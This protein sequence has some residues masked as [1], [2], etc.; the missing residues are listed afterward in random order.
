[1][2]I[3]LPRRALFV[4]ACFIGALLLAPSAYADGVPL[5]R[6]DVL[7]GVGSGVVKHFD[8]NGNL[9]DTLDTTTGST[10]TTGMCFA[11]GGN[12]YV[13]TFNQNTTSVF[14][15]NGNL[16]Q[17]NFGSGYGSDPE[18]CTTNQAGDVFAGQADGSTNILEFDPNGN[19]INTFAPT[20]SPRGTDWIDL[21]SDQCTMQYTSEGSAIHQFNVCTNTQL[22]DFATGLPGGACFAHRILPDGSVLVACSSEVVH[23][24]SSGNI[25]T[26]YPEP[27]D[28]S[29][30]LFALNIDPDGTSFW[31]GGL[32]T[33]D[34]WKI[35]IASGNELEHFNAGINTALGGLA[36][37]GEFTAGSDPTITASGTAVSAIEGRPFSGHVATFTDPDTTA[38]PSDY[39]ATINWGDG[40]TSTGT[41]SGSGGN[42]TVTGTH[43]YA[44]EGSFTVHVTITDTDNSENTA[45][46]T[47]K[48]T[49]ADAALTATGVVPSRS[50][51]SASGTVATFTDADP[52]GTVSDYTASINW[53]DGATSTG[54][55]S[56]GSSNFAVKGSHTYA[57]PGTYTIKT[58]IRDV[59]GSTATATTTITIPAVVRGHASVA[60]IGAACVRHPFT[61]HVRGSH[62][63][64]VRFTLGAS[65]LH[66]TT[67]HRGK[68]YSA[69][70]SVAPGTHTLTVNVRFSSASHTHSRTFHKTIV[71]C[72]AAAPTFTG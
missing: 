45:T 67:V 58:T 4:L 19:L 14:D 59:G 48:A 49:V 38:V 40:S 55:V 52:N 28:G 63:A 7:A 8:P 44:E 56:K 31:T 32:Q 62:I 27:T 9:V 26:T 36:V 47:A 3:H 69:H 35:D 29:G 30:T 6:G 39:S 20:T 57:K 33:G 50:G 22:P 15:K 60:G 64:S 5:N 51:N 18:S 54:A 42:F 66:T 43:T 71:G 46:T 21:A 25:I 2:G 17:A 70:V 16:V 34:V 68:D 53:G 13:T 11:N 41:I 65:K 37:V 12:L 24:D 10:F 61:V 23:L 1:M 72:A